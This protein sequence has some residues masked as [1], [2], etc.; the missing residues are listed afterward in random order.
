MLSEGH[1]VVLHPLIDR[2]PVLSFW[3]FALEFHLNKDDQNCAALLALESENSSLL[4]SPVLL[5]IPLKE[6]NAPR[7]VISVKQI[8]SSHTRQGEGKGEETLAY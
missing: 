2:F 7:Q 4:C 1:T 3:T 8:N 5:M 6:R